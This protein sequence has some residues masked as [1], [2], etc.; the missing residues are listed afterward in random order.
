M[1]NRPGNLAACMSDRCFADEGLSH[2]TFRLPVD[3]AR[4]KAREILSQLPEGGHT[5]VV[6]QWRQMPDGQ[7]EFTMRR[8]RTPD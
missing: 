4:N 1:T 5:S 8:Y 2:E 7:I 3:A 6:E